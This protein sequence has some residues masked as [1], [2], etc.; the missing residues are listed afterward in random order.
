[1]GKDHGS[2]Q[3]MVVYAIGHVVFDIVTV[4]TVNSLDMFPLWFNFAAPVVF[5]LFAILFSQ[6]SFCYVVALPYG[7]RIQKTARIGSACLLALYVILLP[8]LPIVYVQGNGTNYSLGPAAF[9]GYGL[10]MIFFISSAIILGVHYN[11]VNA[12]CEALSAGVPSRMGVATG[13]AV[14]GREYATLRDVLRVADYLMYKNKADMKRTAAFLTKDGQRLNMT[15]LTT[16]FSMFLPPQAPELP[17][18]GQS[19]HQRLPPV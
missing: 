14:S 16:A 19:V 8:V 3:R 2:F 6:E 4:L 17:H 10:A 15:G 13:Y 12:D 11:Q 18:L 9:M 5:Y 7:K 1:M